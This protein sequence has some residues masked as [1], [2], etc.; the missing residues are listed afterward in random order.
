MN[1]NIILTIIGM[2]SAINLVHETPLYQRLLTRLK[3]DRKPFSCVLC[4]TFWCTFG[5]TVITNPAESIFISSSA[6]ILAE[7]IN[8][9][10]HKI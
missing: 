3:V 4:S 7:L 9:N 2:A 1:S 5:F 6:A 10:I 8:I